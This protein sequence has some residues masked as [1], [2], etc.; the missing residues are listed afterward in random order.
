M[1]GRVSQQ[2][3]SRHSVL[4]GCTGTMFAL[5]ALIRRAIEF[6]CAPDAETLGLPLHVV[7]EA[8]CFLDSYVSRHVQSI[9]IA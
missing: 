3:I 9:S 8:V 5:F 7:N 6:N 4:E 2:E 1:S